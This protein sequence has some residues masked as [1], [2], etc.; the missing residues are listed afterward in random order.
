MPESIAHAHFTSVNVKHGQEENDEA[1]GPGQYDVLSGLG[2]CVGLG[3]GGH[4]G[5]LDAGAGR[6]SRKTRK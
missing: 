1:P 3:A 4:D 6:D 2:T 5:N